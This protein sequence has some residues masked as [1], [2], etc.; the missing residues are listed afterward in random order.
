[1]NKR[2]GI[3]GLLHESNTFIGS[4][5]TLRH[6]EEDVLAVGDRFYMLYEGVRGPGPGD[7]GDTQFGVGLARSI[8]AQIDGP[9]E[10][11]AHNPILVDL[12]GNV[13]LG[14]AD[15]I[16]LDGQTVL[17]TSLDGETRSRLVLAW[18]D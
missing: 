4:Q 11:F 6:F 14:H 3:I 8:S 1:M 10:T 12:P 16:I 17:F 2:V 18:H 5:T 13:G 7:A 15:L 9:W